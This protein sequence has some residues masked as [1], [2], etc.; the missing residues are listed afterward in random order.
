MSIPAKFDIQNNSD[1]IFNE[2]V[3]P[4]EIVVSRDDGF[5]TND[6][7]IVFKDQSVSLIVLN[8]CLWNWCFMG[9]S[10]RVNNGYNF[11]EL[12]HDEE[13]ILLFYNYFMM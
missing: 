4:K 13:I 9:S 8:F 12:Y 3:V 6:A 11:K 2:S 10:L 5:V 1:D 7:T